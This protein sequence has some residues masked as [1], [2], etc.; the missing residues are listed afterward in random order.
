MAR[1][2]WKLHMI[3]GFDSSDIT[4][5][6]DS[7]QLRLLDSAD[8][9]A[10]LDY[11]LRNRE[12]HAAWSPVPPA[13]FFT[14]G[15]QQEKIDQYRLAH[16]RGSEYRFVIVPALD[17]ETIVG[18]INLVSIERGVYLNGRLGYSIDDE[19]GGRGVMTSALGLVVDFAFDDLDLHR[20]EAN[21]MPR[22]FRSRRV[23]EKCGF[24]RVGFSPKMLCING[25]WEDHEM[26]AL[27]VDDR[28]G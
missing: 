19:W 6:V 16:R 28:P 7:F 26:Y 9:D 17:E 21:V 18:S 25:V 4:P 1:R 14:P 2:F 5:S 20:L 22:N 13:G 23:L 8:A 27:L 15:Y 3:M 12:A 11:Y 10:M 24:H